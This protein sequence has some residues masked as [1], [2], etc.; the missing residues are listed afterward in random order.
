MHDKFELEDMILTE[1]RRMSGFQHVDDIDVGLVHFKGIL[2]LGRLAERL[3]E[4][5]TAVQQHGPAIPP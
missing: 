1:L 4:K 3:W 5:L 2:D